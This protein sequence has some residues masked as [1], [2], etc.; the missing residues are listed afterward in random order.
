MLD[1]VVGRASL[2]GWSSE[3]M[4]AGEEVVHADK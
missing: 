4:L 3:A 1:S 2:R